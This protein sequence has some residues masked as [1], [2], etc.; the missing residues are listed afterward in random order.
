[1]VASIF[2]HIFPALQQLRSS[3]GSLWSK[4]WMLSVALRCGNSGMDAAFLRKA[5]VVRSRSRKLN[6]Q[7]ILQHFC[8]NIFFFTQCWPPCRLT[9]HGHHWPPIVSPWMVQHVSNCSTLHDPSWFYMINAQDFGAWTQDDAFGR[10][11][12]HERAAWITP[13]EMDFCHRRGATEGWLG[14]TQ[15]DQVSRPGWDTIIYLFV[16]ALRNFTAENFFS[17]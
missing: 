17:M 2:A 4:L 6:W 12:A 8:A 14:R 7:Q 11:R 16:L 10:W 5:E 1:M 3:G 15:Q 13:I 9:K